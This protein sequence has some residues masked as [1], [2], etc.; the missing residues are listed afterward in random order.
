MKKQL[1]LILALL[2]AVVQG[3]WA[4][5]YNVGN[6]TDLKSAVNNDGA[7]ITLTAD[8]ALSEKLTIS[9]GKT[10][11]I[12]LNGKKLS[13]SLSA[14]ENYGMVIYVNGGNL[15]IKDGSGDNSGQI[16]GG[17]SYNGAGVLCESGS[18]L[19]LNGG[20][21]T[22][23]DVS[24][25]EGDHGRGGA[26][27]MNPNTTLTITG[28]V[29]DGNSAYNGGAIYIDDGG[30]DNGTPASATISGA[31]FKN[32]WV[33]GDGG[34]IYNKGTL[35]V[36]DCTISGNSATGVSG[37]GGGGLWNSSASTLELTN[38]VVTRNECE[39]NGGGVN[40]HGNATIS[41]CTFTSNDAGTSGGGIYVDASGNTITFGDNI[42]MA[43]NAGTTG[44]GICLYDGTLNMSG[45]PYIKANTDDSNNDNNLYLR[46]SNVINVTGSFSKAGIGVN[47][48]DYGRG[49]T[50]GFSTYN[51]GTDPST[52]FSM[53]DGFH[54][55]V[56]MDGEVYPSIPYVER[57]WEGGDTDGQVVE[58]T[59]Y[60]TEA[61][62]WNGKDNLTDGWYY[63]SG[64]KENEDNRITVSGDA[65]LIL[66]DGCQLTLEV[67][68][69]IEDGSTL[70][71]YGQ[72]DDSGKLR[73]T[74]DGGS[75]TQGDAAIGGNN[76]VV[77]GNLIIHGG[78]IYAYPYHDNA[79]GIG[80]GNGEGSGM[81]S[82]TIYGGTIEAK[83]RANGAG[84]GMGLNNNTWPTVTIYGGTVTT[85][86]GDFA[87]GIGGGQNRGNGTVK[88]YGGT[89]NATGGASSGSD[90]GGAGIGGG[91]E[92]DQDYPI[93]I[94][95]GTVTATA[96]R[97]ASGIGGGGSTGQAA[98]GDG[99]IIEIYG[100]TVNATSSYLGAGIGGGDKGDGGTVRIDGGTVNVTVTD[101]SYN[102]SGI[103]SGHTGTGGT[104][105]IKG[106]YIKINMSGNGAF[107]GGDK[108]NG[109]I[110]LASDI[111]VKKDDGE[112]VAVSDSESATSGNRV[113]E[114]H[115][116][117]NIYGSGNGSE[118]IIEVC[119]HSGA[120]YSQKDAGYHS[121]SCSY[122]IT[123][124]EEHSFDDD[125][126]CSKCSYEQKTT[127][128]SLLD[129]GDNTVVLAEY[130]GETVD[131]DYDRELTTGENGES[132]AYTVCLPY[133]VDASEN[134]EDNDDEASTAR[135]RA[136]EE[137]A[138]VK[139]FTLAA[140]D[141]ENKQ[142]IF[143]DAPTFIPAGTPVVVVV[144][145][146]SVKLNAE[147]VVLNA[148]MLGNG[149][150]VYASFEDYEAQGDNYI[151]Y[152]TGSY[153]TFRAFFKA[154]ETTD[155]GT[156]VP[157]YQPTDGEL[158]AFPADKF[159]DD[160]ASGTPTGI[161]TTDF[162]DYTD[163]AGAWYSLDGR[164]I[165][166][167]KLPK[168]VY[169][170]NGVKRVIK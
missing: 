108:D 25:H 43:N 83:G 36:S 143:T 22:D 90:G 117:A 79:A 113:S 32:C 68:I 27:F 61:S 97:R 45:N 118:R 34:A 76:K 150:P 98:G 134:A 39:G 16:T 142:F 105:T 163:K 30:P 71:I 57:S 155:V 104:V 85:K 169:I 125:G 165:V 140:V 168:G 7:N 64:T 88:I 38:S 62:S 3:A 127:T 111:M 89:I 135:S 166:N 130:D 95:G 162:T 15:T 119:D 159:A 77:G 101:N 41:G 54:K 94:Y 28:G 24:R 82:V 29:F 21:F 80:G 154:L 35:T 151:G 56:L 103:G 123:T 120:T 73:C 121:V 161:T 11:T 42:V 96:G 126:K 145:K 66:T 23:N 93:Y 110:E 8:I 160:F 50:S 91:R 17:R 63:F 20:T 81:R 31:E 114:L 9:S 137:D 141:E 86:G 2:C 149:M 55:A 52:I 107:I 164:K 92:G 49:F 60:A 116:S 158:Q 4:T 112:K 65:K 33:T 40:I 87:A 44:G 153:D 10:V 129:G 102:A 122:C 13:R 109:T 72:S 100:G 48:E 133:D 37:S 144:Y 167:G 138:E 51:D 131:V 59:K 132:V 147:A 19:T 156:Y 14:N 69:Y 47:L 78:D 146:G 75:T 58:T 26:I 74:G 53:D 84:I 6:E 148:T 152:W 70:T 12:D 67:G 128:I 115:K 1:F 124:Q 170:Y 18:A 136:L 157:M 5:D 46:G 139:V 99:G 106:G